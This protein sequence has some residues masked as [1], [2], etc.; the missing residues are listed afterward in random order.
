MRGSQNV[1]KKS[2]SEIVGAAS[3]NA[4]IRF[5]TSTDVSALDRHLRKE[6]QQ[7][8]EVGWPRPRS[9]RIPRFLR[10]RAPHVD[11]CARARPGRVAPRAARRRTTRPTCRG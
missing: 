6:A 3:A 2:A 8:C 1:F 10:L 4:P 11:L 7:R 5:R 9:I